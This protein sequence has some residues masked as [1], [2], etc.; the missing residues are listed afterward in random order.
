MSAIPGAD[1]LIEAATQPTSKPPT[2]CVFCGAS[3]G[4]SP[5][6]LAAARELAHAFHARGIHLVYG[7]GTVGV[8]G[9]IAK[10]LV[11]LSGPDAVHGVIPEAL[12]RYE[13]GNVNSEAAKDPQQ[14]QQAQAQADEDVT[15][16]LIETKGLIDESIYGRITVVKDMHSRKQMM[17]QEVIS[18]GPGGGFVA[19]SGG[20]GTME[21]LMEVV[22]WN[23]LGIHA[24]GIVLYNVEGYWDGILQWV[25]TAV[26]A[27]FVSESNRDIMV[28]ARSGEEVVKCLKDYQNSEGRF[29]LK[30]EEQ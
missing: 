11:K 27:G 10:T 13:R 19:L 29:K 2:V 14:Q 20:Y 24:R 4:T 18:S 16:H 15:K 17:A 7:G 28:E 1:Q 25:K 9:E 5:A 6:H 8:M 12:L 22:T 3:P 30:W 21:E 26:G 23:Q